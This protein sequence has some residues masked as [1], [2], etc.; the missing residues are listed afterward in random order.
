MG[1]MYSNNSKWDMYKRGEKGG[2]MTAEEL[3]GYSLVQTKCTPC[4]QEPLFTDY[5]F[6][7]IGLSVNPIINDSG[8][9]HITNLH[10]DKYKFKVPSLRNVSLTGPYMHDGRYSTLEECLDHYTNNVTNF[11]NLDPILVPNNG[12]VLSIQD[13]TDII[14]FLNT[15]TDYRFINDKKF[16]DPNMP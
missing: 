3:R 11:V 15:L 8:R 12:I 1:L 10:Y 9:A 16:A 2:S 6:R 7:S 14:A 5:S 13:K 4:H